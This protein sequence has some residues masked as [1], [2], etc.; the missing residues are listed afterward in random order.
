MDL[1]CDYKNSRSKNYDNNTKSSR[2]G[3][4][5]ELKMKPYRP[6]TITIRNHNDWTTQTAEDG[7]ETKTTEGNFQPST[8]YRPVDELY[9]S[10][11]YNISYGDTSS[12]LQTYRLGWVLTPKLQYEAS[13]K[14][15]NDANSDVFDNS[16]NWNISRY[17]KFDTSYNIANYKDENRS[18]YTVTTRYIFRF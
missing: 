18:V 13:Y 8:T 11:N 6:L 15:D 12:T 3:V 5:A 2:N 17:M 10:A 1:R 16:L 4:G 14:Y 7:M 9:L